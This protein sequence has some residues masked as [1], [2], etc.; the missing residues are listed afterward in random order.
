M[1]KYY[2]FESEGIG[3]VWA[4]KIDPARLKHL[5]THFDPNITYREVDQTTYRKARSDLV[6]EGS[7]RLI[8]KVQENVIAAMSGKTF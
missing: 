2:L 1:R 7:N 8:Q 5:A 4:E 6:Q 3:L